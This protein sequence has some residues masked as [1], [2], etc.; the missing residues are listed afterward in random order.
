MNKLK[1]LV[2]DDTELNLI[3]ISR[4]IEKLGHDVIAAR[5]GEEAVERFVQEQPDLVLM[6]VMMPVMDGYQACAKI[7][8]LQP[9]HWVPVIFLSALSTDQDMV[10]GLEAGGDDYM[11]KPVSL[12]FLEAKIRAMQR[13]AALQAALRLKADDLAAAYFQLDEEASLGGHLMEHLINAGTL[14]DP[15]V[16]HW[17]V[18]VGQFSGDLI[19]V[20]RSHGGAL[21]AMLADAAGHGLAAALNVLPATEVFQAMAARG[22]PVGTIAAEINRKLRALMPLDRFIATALVCVDPLREIVEIWNGGSPD[23]LML[24]KNGQLIAR[25][26]SQH[27][28]LGILPDNQFS[29]RVTVFDY[30]PAAQ[31]FFCSDGLI[32]AEAPD[33]EPLDLHRIEQ[34]LAVSTPEM[35]LQNLKDL[36]HRHLDGR[37]PHDDISL[38][39]LNLPDPRYTDRSASSTVLPTELPLTAQANWGISFR[40]G[41]VQLRQLDMVPTITTMLERMD[42]ASAHTGQ[43]HLILS[44]L[45]T[46]AMDHGILRLDSSIKESGGF[47]AYLKTREERLANISSGLIEIALDAYESDGAMVIRIHVRDSG[48]G[49]DF[50]QYLDPHGSSNLPH[51]RGIIL[52]RSL[53]EKIEFLGTGNEVMAWYRCSQI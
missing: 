19:T 37:S 20:T 48:P 12:V 27:P 46:N 6:D 41:I 25:C 14:Q 38:I 26:C 34:A 28:P 42:S 3:L 9:E 21:Y 52:A 40:F 7:R 16:Q 18:P 33:G 53:C 1:V 44:E 13:I 30:V 49:F 51:G 32:E 17:L 8:Q 29:N 23:I 35:R 4:F 5:N 31:V 24:A 47:E 43:L 50:R 45:F 2:A 11:T 22:F 39:L 36:L 15:L 10:N